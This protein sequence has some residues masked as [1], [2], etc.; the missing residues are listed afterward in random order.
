MAVGMGMEISR[1]T[2]AVTR[3]G[4]GSGAEVVWDGDRPCVADKR[5]NFL[6]RGVPTNPYTRMN[7]IVSVCVLCN[8]YRGSKCDR[9]SRRERFTPE[10]AAQRIPIT[11]P[12]VTQRR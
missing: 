9:L 6:V 8:P 10:A 2:T 3:R 12:R 4:H 5:P 1:A 11:G 7:S